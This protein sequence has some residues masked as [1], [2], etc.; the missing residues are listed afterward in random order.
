MEVGK[1]GKLVDELFVFHSEIVGGLKNLNG[2]VKGI[3]S[4]VCFGKRRCDVISPNMTLSAF[5]CM[6]S[7]H[8]P[9]Q[10]GAIRFKAYKA[11]YIYK[12]L[13]QTPLDNYQEKDGVTR[14]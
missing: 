6:Q 9:S 11:F 13:V 3:S 1:L 4:I 12:L 7:S 14:G 2:S 8:R 5:M 10:G